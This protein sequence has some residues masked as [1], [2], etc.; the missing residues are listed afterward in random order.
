VRTLVPALRAAAPVL[1]LE[2]HSHETVAMAG[3]SYLEAARLG[4]S[5]V[6][7]AVRP[8]ANGT[9]QPAAERTV[10]NLR[11][12]GV[13]VPLDESALA[14]MSAYF[15]RLAGLIGRPVGVPREHDVSVYRH[16]LPG[17]MTST[18]RR[19]LAEVGLE[20]RFDDVLDELPRVREELGWPIMVTPL[21]QFVGVQAFLN[22]TTGERWS[23]IPDEVVRYVLGQ[24][25]PPPGELDPDVEARVLA[26]PHAE[27]LRGEEHRLDLAQARARW[28]ERMSDEELLL[29][30]TMPPEQVDAIGSAPAARPSAP[31]RSAVVELVAGLAARGL[32]DVEVE[33]PGLR[34]RL[35]R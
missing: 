27:R 19:Q 4:A 6:C 5:F 33:A 31:A 20:H 29:R 10:A 23:Q 24:Y 34:V 13:D 30:M 12:D 11:A 32:D 25:G 7:T 1:P 3:P 21:S 35:R 18:L 17:G 22:V 26:S 28:G 14:E 16:Q 15:E 9:S 2:V 8:L